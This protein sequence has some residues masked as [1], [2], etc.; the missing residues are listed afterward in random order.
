MRQVRQ[1]R[2][3]RGKV[4]P[5][6]L[7]TV[8]RRLGVAAIIVAGTAGTRAAVQPQA[9]GTTLVKAARVIDGRGGAPIVNAGVLIRGDRI[10]RVGPAAGMT[11]D[12]VIDL[13]SATV[14]PG[15]IDLHTH[16]TDEVGTNWESALLTTTPGR[17]AIYGA[18]NARTTLEAGFTSVRN[19]GLM[20]KTGGYLLDVALM[21]AIDQGWHIGPRIFPAGHAVTPYGGH[22]DPTVFQRLAPGIMPLSVAE[23]IANGFDGLWWSGAVGASGAVFGMFGAFLVLQRRLG[24]SAAG[25]YVMIGINAVIGFVIPGIAWQAHLGGLLTGAACAAA[26]G[27]L[28]RPTSLMNRGDTRLHWAGL[29]AI[30]V[31]LVVLTV[32][33]YALA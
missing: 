32:V 4:R 12:Q 33:K 10:E 15:L 13:G 7:S 29:G 23:G 20:V 2:Q 30:L 3:V 1:V 11:A 5:M 14:L 21:R 25:M 27:Y 28:G 8:A 24:R 18:V 17:A 16:L 19:L 22:L 6:M 26:I 9:P 31:L